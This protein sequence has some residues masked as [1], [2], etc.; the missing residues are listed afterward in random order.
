M[1][2]PSNVT[3]PDTSSESIEIVNQVFSIASGVPS[4][5]QVYVTI[6]YPI[7]VIFMLWIAASNFKEELQISMTRDRRD[8]EKWPEIYKRY[9]A[10]RKFSD[11]ISQ[12]FGSMSA[13]FTMAAA[14][15]LTIS[16]D[17]VLISGRFE[18]KLSTVI[19]NTVFFS[20]LLLAAD[21]SNQVQN[22]QKRVNLSN[23]Y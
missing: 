1:N 9:Q 4:L 23:P 13:I 14:L 18:D 22:L 12:T 16:I 6:C 21:V 15:S 10:I 7:M 8:G 5:I 17:R 11:Q 20:V 2:K 19:G 3:F